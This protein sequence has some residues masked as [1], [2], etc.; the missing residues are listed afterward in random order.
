[1]KNPS[2]LAVSFGLA[3]LAGTASA[4]NWTTSMT[5]GKKQSNPRQKSITAPEGGGATQGMKYETI[6]AWKDFEQLDKLDDAHALV[7]RHGEG[8]A[9]NLESLLLP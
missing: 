9:L 8:G 7:I 5:E 2:L 6:D 1:M 4:A 3:L